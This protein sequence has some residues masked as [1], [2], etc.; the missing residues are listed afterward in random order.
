MRPATLAGG[1]DWKE[2]PA[3]D[4]GS[5]ID[6]THETYVTVLRSSRGVIGAGGLGALNRGAARGLEPSSPSEKGLLGE[7]QASETLTA[8]SGKACF[9]SALAGVPKAFSGC[10][11]KLRLSEFVLPIVP[12][13]PNSILVLNAIGTQ[14]NFV[15]SSNYVVLE[16]LRR[17]TGAGI[18]G[19]K[20]LGLLREILL[21]VAL[22]A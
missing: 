6:P 12:R 22:Q 11:T 21:G 9:E 10:S 1:H 20:K 16:C 18:E 4:V 13:N 19:S 2:E 17:D 15:L 14:N 7:Y 3:G 8:R 5:R